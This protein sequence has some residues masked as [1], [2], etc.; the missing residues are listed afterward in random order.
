M[1]IF[2]KSQAAQ[3]F[4][5]DEA[6][7]ML[8]AE[9]EGDLTKVFLN[10]ASS[11]EEVQEARDTVRGLAAIRRKVRSLKDA[12]NRAEKQDRHRGND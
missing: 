8:I 10:D 6:C 5:N 1:N 12:A 11:A 9:I 3:R 2:D 4:W 7:K